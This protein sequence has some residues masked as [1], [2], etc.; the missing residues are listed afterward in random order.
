[1]EEI[2]Y[3]FLDMYVGGGKEIIKLIYGTVKM[4]LRYSEDNTL[5]DCQP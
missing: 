2:V 4:V 3:E 1:M 5:L